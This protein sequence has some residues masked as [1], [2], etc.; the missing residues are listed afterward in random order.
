MHS[1]VINDL[2]GQIFA[3]AYFFTPS[4]AR[5]AKGGRYANGAMSRGSGAADL[6]KGLFFNDATLRG[7][8]PGSLDQP[9]AVC[10]W[11]QNRVMV[12]KCLT[13]DLLIEV[14]GKRI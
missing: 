14:P 4:E 6:G 7:R 11:P 9:G 3:V 1:L 13:L 12:G 8:P 5:R 10:G 2:H